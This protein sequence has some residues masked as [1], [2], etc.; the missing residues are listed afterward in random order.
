M[1]NLECLHPFGCDQ[2]GVRKVLMP[3]F[4]FGRRLES[5]CEEHAVVAE[6]MKNELRWVWGG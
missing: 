4:I 1:V 3:S 2:E 5:F 6:R